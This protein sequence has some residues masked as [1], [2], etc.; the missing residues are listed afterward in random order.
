[1]GN[2][3][4]VHSSKMGDR[5]TLGLEAAILTLLPMI[6]AFPMLRIARFGPTGPANVW[7]VLLYAPLAMWMQTR[8]IGILLNMYRNRR[9]PVLFVVL[10]LGIVSLCT[11]ALSG[12]VFV[13]ALPV[14]L[15]AIPLG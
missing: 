15:S 4:V 5:R 2:T 12:F 11:C 6:L 8:A 1:M 13:M 9:D 3:L 14:V 10:P 7:P